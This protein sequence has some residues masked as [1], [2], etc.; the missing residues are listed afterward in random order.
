MKVKD[1]KAF[2]ADKHDDLEVV[3]VDGC[4]DGY[5]EARVSVDSATRR[6]KIWL[7]DKEIWTSTR[8]WVVVV[9]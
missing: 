2:L 3:T 8:D 5:S 6:K 7:N 1:L 9:F 4:D